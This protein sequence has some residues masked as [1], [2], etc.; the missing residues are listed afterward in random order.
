MRQ[1]L[2]VEDEV[3]IAM[4]LESKLQQAGFRVLGPFFKVRDALLAIASQPPDLAILDI[5]MHDEKSVAVAEVLLAARVPFVTLTGYSE[6][7]VPAIYRSS[8]IVT[9]PFDIDTLLQVLDELDRPTIGYT[10]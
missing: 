4:E 1:I 6:Q 9:K 7:E 5:N 3:L 8:P 10:I 2:I